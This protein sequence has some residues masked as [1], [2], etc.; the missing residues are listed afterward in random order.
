MGRN[1]PAPQRRYG[2][3]T[4]NDSGISESSCERC[5]ITMQCAG[6]LVG[7]RA[8]FSKFNRNDHAENTT[9]ESHAKTGACTAS[10][11]YLFPGRFYKQYENSPETNT[12]LV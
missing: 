1:S 2:C 4:S 9:Y 3:T 7:K 8:V 6:K 5:C 11:G 10:S 12:A